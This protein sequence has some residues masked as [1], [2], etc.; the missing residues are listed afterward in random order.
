MKKQIEKQREKQVSMLLMDVFK[1]VN[2][3]SMEERVAMVVQ[4][5]RFAESVRLAEVAEV[6]RLAMEPYKRMN[7][8]M[9]RVA[10]SVRLA[11]EPLRT[12]RLDFLKIGNVL[13]TMYSTRFAVAEVARFAMEPYKRMNV[14]MTRVAEVARLATEPYKRM[15]VEMTRVAESV[16]LATEPL[17]TLRLDFLKMGNV[18]SEPKLLPARLSAVSEMVDVVKENNKLSVERLKEQRRTN[19]LLERIVVRQIVDGVIDQ[20]ESKT[21]YGCS[22]TVH[23]EIGF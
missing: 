4:H 6:A 5:T 3:Q 8:E 10:E 20:E 16:R 14:E 7:V 17:R 2:F 18:L 12:L 23:K 15:N 13:N 11:T 21:E 19:V 9:T 22:D 1:N